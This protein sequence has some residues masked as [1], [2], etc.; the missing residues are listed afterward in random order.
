MCHLSSQPFELNT[1]GLDRR[2]L[3]RA[4]LQIDPP[5]LGQGHESSRAHKDHCSESFIYHSQL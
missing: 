3:D 2:L 5:F 1:T 4:L